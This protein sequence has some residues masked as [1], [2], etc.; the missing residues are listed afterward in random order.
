MLERLHV[1][2]GV[3]GVALERFK[4]Y[5]R[6]RSQ[7]VIVDDVV[8]TP[9]PRPYGVPQGSVLWVVLFTPYSQPLSGVISD[10]DYD[11]HKYVDDM[12]FSQSAPPADFVLSSQYSDMYL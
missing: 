4:S 2:F 1:S 12:G 5:V 10:Y 6:D 11:F 7:A 9:V 8:S 3:R